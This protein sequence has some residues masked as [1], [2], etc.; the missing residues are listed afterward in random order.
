M[1]DPRN[2]TSEIFKRC[3]PMLKLLSDKKYL[4]NAHITQIFKLAENRHESEVLTIFGVVA[5]MACFVTPD[6][7]DHIFSEIVRLRLN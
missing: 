6:S 2:F 7:L 3:V 4:G 1:I 5:E